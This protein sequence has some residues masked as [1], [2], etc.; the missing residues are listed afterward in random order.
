M[1]RKQFVAEVKALG[2]EESSKPGEFSAVV[3]VFD[4]VDRVGDRVKAS[5]FDRTLEAWR[6]SGDPIPVVLAHDWSNPMSHIGYAMPENVLA[7]PGKG[8]VV[9]KAVLDID[10]NPVARQVHRLMQRRTLKEFSFGYNV[11]E[12]GESKASD[13]AY[14]LTDLDLIEFG[15][16]LKGVNPETEL[17][18]VKAEVDAAARRESGEEPSFEERITA[19]EAKL[20]DSRNV[21][22]L[23]DEGKL[24]WIADDVDAS[25][26]LKLPPAEE[27]KEHEEHEAKTDEGEEKAEDAPETKEETPEDVKNLELAMIDQ[28]LDNL[29]ASLPFLRVDGELDEVERDIQARENDLRG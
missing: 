19:L 7:V 11:A 23:T 14:D 4:N 3:S 5:A 15:P 10:D 9:T 27:G 2:P 22:V 28:G 12:G 21:A 6:K 25:E 1:L 17:L 29:E 26:I 8:L 18:A 24:V 16:C 13:G 20:K